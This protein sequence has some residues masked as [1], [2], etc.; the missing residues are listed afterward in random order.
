MRFFVLG[1]LLAGLA[2]KAI[3]EPMGGRE[4][5]KLMFNPAKVEVEL[6][7]VAFLSAQ[8]TAILQEVAKQQPYYTAIAASPSEGLMSNSLLAAAKFHDTENAATAALAGCNSRKAEDADP[9]E[10]VALIRPEGWEARA[11]Q[12]SGEATQALRKEYRRGRAPKAMAIS[13][14][15]GQ[16]AIAKG[17]TANDDALADCS[18][19]EGATDCI[20]AVAD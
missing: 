16:W 20:V 1:L 15:T 13:A 5:R 18:A 7:D 8:D 10:I 6:I 9:C 2:G 17:E 12:L 4:A 3:A 19:R 11:L 14:A